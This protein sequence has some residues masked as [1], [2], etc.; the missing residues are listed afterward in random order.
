MSFT[1]K[2]RAY[3][4]AR[5]S[6]KNIQDSAKE[7]GYSV[8]AARASGSR[9]EKDPDVQAAFARCKAGGK[10]AAAKDPPPKAKIV[11]KTPAKTKKKAAEVPGQLI[12]DTESLPD[13]ASM[14]AAPPTKKPTK[15]MEQK[16]P[17]P[18]LPAIEI[19]DPLEFMRQMMKD[20]GEDP[21]LR[22]EAAKQLAIFTIS[23]PSDKGKKEEQKDAAKEVAKKFGAIAPPKLNLVK[24]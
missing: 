21:R 13:W 19:D 23:K 15:S 16:T 18:E 5:L 24:K 14:L 2:K 7:A 6:G 3:V 4:K 22:L 1:A 10:L 17:K 8:I 12:D 11:N 9:L 20:A